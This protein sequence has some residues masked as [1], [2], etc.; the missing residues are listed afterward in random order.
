MAGVRA[1]VSIFID[2]PPDRV[3]RMVSD[4]T[5]MGEWSPITY[6]CEWLDGSTGP[7]PGAR[8]KGSN[9]MPPA[10]WWTIC[11][12]TESVPGKVFEFRTI[13]GSLNWGARNKEMTRW[14]YTF[15]AEG[16]GTK[17]TESYG[18][19]SVPPALA[20]PERIARMIPGGGRQVDKRRERTNRGMQET[21]ERLKVAAEGVE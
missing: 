9:K 5:R 19:S 14:R 15:E 20:I 4:I 18:V 13:D 1:E 7:V 11:E 17:V 21:L 8:F 16:I 12:V 10:K 6:R 3:W 2:A